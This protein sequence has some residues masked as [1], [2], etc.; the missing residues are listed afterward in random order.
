MY[1]H[2]DTV[3]IAGTKGLQDLLTD[4]TVV[5]LNQTHELGRY[6]RL[7][8]LIRFNPHIKNVVGHSLGSA[9]G[10]HFAD[11]NPR[12]QGKFRLYSW[13]VLSWTQN[14]ARISSF[15]G[16]FDPISLGDRNATRQFRWNPHGFH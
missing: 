12:W 16:R 15:A 11:R 2:G 13:P 5:P 3:Y 10:G 9:V 7:S 4:I 14:D 1:L 8:D 6:K